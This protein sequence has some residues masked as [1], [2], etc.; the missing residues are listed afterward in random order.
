M[1]HRYLAT[2]LDNNIRIFA[3]LIWDNTLSARRH[4]FQNLAGTEFSGELIS[5]LNLSFLSEYRINKKTDLGLQLIIPGLAYILRPGF[6]LGPPNGAANRGINDPNV[7]EIIKA[8]D[9]A[10]VN[11]YLHFRTII[12]YE[13][14]VSDSVGLRFEYQFVFYQYKNPRKTGTVSNQFR[15]EIVMLF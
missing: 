15:F 6:T 1:Y 14:N 8:G 10:T 2:F 5:S 3:G 13:K 4:K 7:N 9:V 11:N 12:A